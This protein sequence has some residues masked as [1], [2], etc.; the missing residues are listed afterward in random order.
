MG[1]GEILLTAV[2]CEGT[3]QGMDCDL[4]SKVSS[5][6]NIPVIAQGGAG[7]IGDIGEGIDRGG[8]SAVALG[9]MVVFQ[10]QG[11]G[12]LV[13]F[14]DKKLIEVELGKH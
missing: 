12:V 1:A 14:P 11:M 13:N 7:N 2:D 5:A 10:K 8:A 6:V 9:S 3:W 4:I